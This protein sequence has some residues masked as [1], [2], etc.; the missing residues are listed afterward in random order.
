MVNRKESLDLLKKLIS[1]KSNY[2][3][4]KEIMEY[5]YDWFKNNDMNISYHYYTDNKVTDFSGINIIGEMKGSEEGPVLLI[6]GHLDTVEE[7]TGW[8]KNPYIPLEEDGKL[9]G[10]GALDMKSGCAAAMIALREF[11]KNIM[12]FKGKII[13][14]FVS[15][16]EGPY[17]LGTNFILNDGLINESDIAIVTEPSSGFLRMKE[18]VICLGARGGYGYSIKIYGKSSHA[19]TPEYGI[20]AV[21]EAGKLIV[22]LS[23]AI[24]VYDE[25]LGHSSHCVI[26][27]EG[28]GAACSVPDNAE[29]KIFR[30]I[31]RGENKNTI[32]KEID[33]AAIRCGLKG[34]YEVIFREAPLENAD[35]F[36][37][38]VVDEK[39]L[40]I[41]ILKDSIKKITSKEA[42]I[43][44]FSSIGD[45]NSIAS[46]L[47]IPVIIY[48]ASGDNFHGSDEAVDIKSFYETVEVLYDFLVKYLA[49]PK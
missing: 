2:F 41:E 22:E 47:N 13:Y 45:F 30:H 46:K 35:G 17:G 32:K 24:P 18:P 33:E 7:C 37:P 39:L 5:C 14:S 20:N 26:E 19:A 9:Y 48:G 42:E 3:H 12:N 11:K 21:D 10:L 8:S 40:E 36:M 25:K 27:I 15:D 34:R 4:E 1:I 44:Y 31:V 16:E 38:Y 43:K 23:K 49:I 28:G 6:N 29:V